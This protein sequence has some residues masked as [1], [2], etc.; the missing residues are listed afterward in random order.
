MGQKGTGSPDP[1]PQHWILTCNLWSCVSALS[2]MLAVVLLLLPTTPAGL[3]FISADIIDT[4]S[5]TI[6]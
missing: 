5:A 6:D 4:L 2:L 3:A 1:D